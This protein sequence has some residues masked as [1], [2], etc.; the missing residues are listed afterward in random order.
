MLLFLEIKYIIANLRKTWAFFKR[1]CVCSI[2]YKYFALHTFIMQYI[3]D[4]F[5][6][7]CLEIEIKSD[8]GVI[9][10]IR[11]DNTCKIVTPII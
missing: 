11:E 4:W 5:S 1:R 8:G 6:M 2:A 7:P 3:I 10:Y 9:T